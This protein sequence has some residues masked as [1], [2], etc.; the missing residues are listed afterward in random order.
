MSAGAG[1]CQILARFLA[2][3]EEFQRI[4][5]S[6]LVDRA[7]IAFLVLPPPQ[8]NFSSNQL[9]GSSALPQKKATSRPTEERQRRGQR[10]VPLSALTNPIRC[11]HTWSCSL[12]KRFVRWSPEME[13]IFLQPERKTGVGLSLDMQTSIIRLVSHLRTSACKS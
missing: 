9:P 10:P 12:A 7:G 6:T 2:S 3:E 4:Q 5:V 8:D 11:R 1:E 13:E